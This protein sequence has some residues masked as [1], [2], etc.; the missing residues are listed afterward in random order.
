V[1]A[2]LQVNIA[3]E[4]LPLELFK[5]VINPRNGVVVPDCDFF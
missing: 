1:V 5:M 2:R 4:L 3:E